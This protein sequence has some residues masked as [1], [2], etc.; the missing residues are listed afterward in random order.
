MVYGRLE[1]SSPS[2]LPDEFLSEQALQ[3]GELKFKL[4]TWIPF[5]FFILRFR[6]Q[7]EKPDR[8][9]NRTSPASYREK[10]KIIGQTETME[11]IN[12]Y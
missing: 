5:L 7:K 11:A 8:M 10:Y 4:R 6:S 1:L 2:I 3:K 9:R 12:A